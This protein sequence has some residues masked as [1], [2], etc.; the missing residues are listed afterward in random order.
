MQSLNLFINLNFICMKK[1]SKKVQSTNEKGYSSLNGEALKKIKG[2]TKSNAGSTD[3]VCGTSCC[4]AT[5]AFV[6]TK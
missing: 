2:G 3:R 4:S 5:A 6:R 1:V